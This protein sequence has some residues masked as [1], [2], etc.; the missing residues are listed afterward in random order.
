MK[1]FKDVKEELLS[2]AY[3]AETIS[4]IPAF[5]AKVGKAGQTGT[6]QLVKLG[7]LGLLGYGYYRTKKALKKA[8]QKVKQLQYDLS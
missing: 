4:R 7:A 3:G 2:E 1:T 5:A 8:D 6:G